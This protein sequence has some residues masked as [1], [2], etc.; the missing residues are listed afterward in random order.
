M[1][2]R[3]F[4]LTALLI[5]SIG[6]AGKQDY[7]IVPREQADGLL[8]ESAV[9]VEGHVIAGR[10]RATATQYLFFIPMNLSMKNPRYDATVAVDR[11]LKGRVKEKTIRLVDYRG[12]TKQEYAAFADGYGIHNHSVVRIGYDRRRGDRLTKLAIVPLGNT[13]EF[14]EALR[15]SEAKRTQRA[16]TRPASKPSK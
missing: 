15:Q 11:V 8:S 10:L 2:Q 9:V 13:P 4:I 14:D 6:C 3:A 7:R 1:W 5:S 12:M 16:A